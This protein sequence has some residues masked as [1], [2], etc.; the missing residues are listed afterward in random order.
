MGQSMSSIA[1]ECNE[2]KNAYDNCFSQWYE[3]FLK[4][5]SLENECKDLFDTYK[6]CVQSAMLKN[7]NVHKNLEDAR[8][9]APFEN[10]GK[11]RETD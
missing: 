10:G 9:Q 1:P 6:T 2:S 4:G 8:E 11:H 5:E 7:H 3:K